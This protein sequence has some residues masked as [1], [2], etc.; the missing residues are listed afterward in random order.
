MMGC[1]C[2]NFLVL[3]LMFLSLIACQQGEVSAPYVP[4]ID[5]GPTRSIRQPLTLNPDLAKVDTLS[6]QTMDD[7]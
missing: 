7:L 5:A 1:K 4:V 2:R 3:V 6:V